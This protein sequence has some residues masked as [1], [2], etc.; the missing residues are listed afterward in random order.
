MRRILIPI[1]A[2]LAPVL[3]VADEG[4]DGSAI[5][6]KILPS[7]APVIT[8]DGTGTG[9]VVDR[10]KRLLVTNYHVVAKLVF[11]ELDGETARNVKVAESVSVMFPVF[12]GG[13]V[14]QDRSFYKDNAKRLEI[15]G[16]VLL[17]GKQEDLAVIKLESLPDDARAL[18]IASVPPGPGRRVHSVGNPGASAGLWVYTSGT[19][20]SVAK[21]MMNSDYGSHEFTAVET[22]APINPGD[23]GGP[24][25]NDAGQVVAVAESINLKGTLM[26]NCVAIAELEK[27]LSIYRNVEMPLLAVDYLNR[28]HTYLDKSQWDLAIADFTQTLELDPKEKDAYWGR[29]AAYSNRFDHQ[30]AL[31]DFNKYLELDPQNRDAYYQR[32]KTHWRAK[33][34][35]RAIED[36]NKAKTLGLN[37]YELFYDRGACYQNLKRVD[38]A[39]A[40]YGRAVAIDPQRYPVYLYI[41]R[42]H[43]NKMQTPWGS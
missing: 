1:L 28:G 11:S 37:S 34:L 13:N 4:A 8:A 30:K 20:R 6:K 36:F 19:V 17:S 5:Y 42:I 21:V 43:G 9:W 23:S 26:S 12:L 25:V 38:W 10:D 3:A 31:S 15:R 33:D 35:L 7:T 41:A 18:E 40:D 22:Q 24:V 29:V 2:L 16:K 39:L 27:L 14:I 32:G